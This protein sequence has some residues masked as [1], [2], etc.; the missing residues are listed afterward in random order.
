MPGWV[1]WTMH[2]REFCCFWWMITFR[3][4]SIPLGHCQVLYVVFVFFLFPGWITKT[5]HASTGIQHA[6]IISYCCFVIF[7]ELICIFCYRLNVQQGSLGENMRSLP[8]WL[9]ANS[10]SW[11]SSKRQRMDSFA[12]ACGNIGWW[13]WPKI[14]TRNSMKSRWRYWKR[15]IRTMKNG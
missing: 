13:S 1:R 11:Q 8:R 3:K 2:R 4:S 10:A 15:Y 12:A 6:P 7:G 14:A 9:T 5:R